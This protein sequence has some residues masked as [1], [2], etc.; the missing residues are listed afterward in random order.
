MSADL[1]TFVQ[2]ISNFACLWQGASR[3]AFSKVSKVDLWP[4]RTLAR[5]LAVSHSLSLSRSLSLARA[6]SLALSRSLSLSFSLF[7]SLSLSHPTSES[8]IGVQDRL[9]DS[10]KDR[11]LKDVSD[12]LTYADVC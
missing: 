6:R 10:M 9:I 8:E 4:E 5:P 2:K 11:S 12:M 1:E 3:N 7:L